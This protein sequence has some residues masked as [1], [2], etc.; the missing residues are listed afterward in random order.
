M[1]IINKLVQIDIVQ[2]YQNYSHIKSQGFNHDNI[3]V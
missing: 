1:L 3:T 2:T